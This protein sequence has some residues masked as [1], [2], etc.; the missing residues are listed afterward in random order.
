MNFL[1]GKL[2]TIDLVLAI[3]SVV[4]LIGAGAGYR[5]GWWGYRVGFL[6]LLV[7]M[8]AGIAALGIAVTG[9]YT[10]L[11]DQGALGTLSIN[12]VILVLSTAAVIFPA[13][14]LWKAFTVPPIHDITT[15]TQNPP[16]FTAIKPF[17]TK[18]TNSTEY[19][20]PEIAAQQHQ[21]YPDIAPLMLPAPPAQVVSL[22]QATVQDMGWKIVAADATT[23]RIE[24]TDTTLWFGFKDD[25]VIRITAQDNG[26]RI[27][28][29]S[30][31]RVGRSDLGA[32]AR[33]INA[34]LHALNARA[35]NGS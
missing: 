28:V 5:F 12:L 7:A 4:V 19:G 18:A 35:S 11:R 16:Q 21:A 22:A 1:T 30:L 20:G 29:R 14:W 27:D 23:H 33:R 8:I 32:N 15:D 34:F 6:L 9:I 3:L 24:A 25:I 17:R 13:S 26:S 10:G 2:I 31:S